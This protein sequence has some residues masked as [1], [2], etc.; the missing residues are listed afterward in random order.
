MPEAYCTHSGKTRKTP[1]DFWWLGGSPP[2]L[3]AAAIVI[4]VYYSDGWDG[5]ARS[6]TPDSINI[7]PAPS[8][9]WPFV[10]VVGRLGWVSCGV[11]VG[12]LKAFSHQ[13]EMANIRV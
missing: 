8:S 12:C 13:E 5:S 3:T 7:S 10:A 2:P 9:F 11:S 1:F 4:L 6:P